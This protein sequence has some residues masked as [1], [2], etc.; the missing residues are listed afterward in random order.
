MVLCC[1]IAV[2]EC[3]GVTD[4]FQKN[5]LNLC[6]RLF[7]GEPLGRKLTC[8]FD[9]LLARPIFSLRKLTVAVGI[10]LKVGLR[11]DCS[12]LKNRMDQHAGVNQRFYC[13]G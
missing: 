10:R 7:L 6:E 9:R 4:V 12:N 11:A 8:S 5:C 2:D 1:R 3:G 13:L